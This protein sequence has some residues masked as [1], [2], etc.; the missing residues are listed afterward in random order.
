M[1]NKMDGLLVPTIDP[2]KNPN[3]S[4]EAKTAGEE[5][6]KPIDFS[7]IKNMNA[8]DRLDHGTAAIIQEKAVTPKGHK[9]NKTFNFVQSEL[10]SLASAGKLYGNVTS[11]PDILNG[12]IRLFPMTTQE[13]E[14]LSTP[15]YLKTG[16][17]TRMIFE[18]CIDSDIDA[19]EILLFDSNMLLFALRQISYGN[20]YRFK[21]K[22]GNSSC[23]K[24]FEH[25]IKIN[26][27][28]FDS[29]PEGTVEPIVTF[30]PKTK[31]TVYTTLPRLSN[32]EAL[33][34]RDVNRK[35]NKTDS[36]QRIVD[37]LMVTTFKI[38]DPS[39]R[40]VPQSQWEEFFKAIP[41]GDRA[42]ITEAN[43]F[44][45]GFDELVGVTCP[46]C[47]EEYDGTIPVGID[48]FRL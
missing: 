16:S 22:C 31:Y 14:I 4:N 11:D 28:N 38:T 2:S 40:E 1:S 18:N 43:T 30:L 45:S 12:F 47:E 35:K 7:N 24:E 3:F 34:M 27:L 15:R 26:E 19:K 36:N 5:P 44:K 46:H 21:L 41:G 8:L 42:T 17:A 23:G 29:L 39:G 32:S 33:Y 20:D 13:E 6:M 37:N 9:R 25:T 10:V 48:F